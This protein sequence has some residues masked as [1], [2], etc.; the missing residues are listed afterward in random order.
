MSTDVHALYR[1]FKALYQDYD[2]PVSPYIKKRLRHRQAVT[3]NRCK[4]ELVS[5]MLDHGLR[6]LVRERSMPDPQTFSIQELVRTPV[7]EH[8]TRRWARLLQ[9]GAVVI[10]GFR[11]RSATETG[12]GGAWNL[13]AMRTPGSTELTFAGERRTAGIRTAG[14]LRLHEGWCEMDLTCTR[15][16]STVFERR[17]ALDDRE[18]ATTV[19][20]WANTLYPKGKKCQEK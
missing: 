15:H 9:L 6:D 14:R 4:L 13:Q 12:D 2:P 3:N 7:A 5:D 16:G 1:R 10:D 11:R 19:D 17:T 8:E 18:L 20:E